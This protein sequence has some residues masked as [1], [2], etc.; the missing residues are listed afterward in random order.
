[1]KSIK[2]P[3]C[4]SAL[5]GLIYGI[6]LVIIGVLL[7]FN[8][9]ILDGSYTLVGAG[10]SLITFYLVKYVQEQDFQ[11]FPFGKEAFIPLMMFIQYLLI[12]AISIYGLVDVVRSLQ[13]IESTQNKSIGLYVSIVGM[14]SCLLFW[15]FLKKQKIDH[16]FIHLEIE[17]WRFGFFF[18]LGVSASFIFSEIV[19]R[20]QWHFIAPYIDA[21]ISIIITASF[22]VLA[23]KELKTAIL[24]LTSAAP[25]SELRR[26]I[27]VIVRKNF[28]RKPIQT[29]LLRTAKVG[30]QLI[31]ELDI[32]IQ[33]DS[34]YDSVVM[35]DQLRSELLTQIENK[36][37]R[38][39]IW[40][41]L[42]FMCDIKWAES[43][44]TST[45]K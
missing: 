27:E 10:M 20:T 8:V 30:N 17:Q 21:M 1:M 37:I 39:S 15:Q 43:K 7:N 2:R 5:F 9:L 29:F 36:I 14:I 26:K 28:E 23:I 31:L 3:L 4:Q 6:F 33:P 45:I 11:N 38:E 16:P 32:I 35:Q 44:D 24:E 22:I 18:S 12:L 13:S 41:N 34:Q 19:L 25:K 40:F 42:N